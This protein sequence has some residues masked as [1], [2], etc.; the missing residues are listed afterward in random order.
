MDSKHAA[1]KYVENLYQIIDLGSTNGTFVNDVEILQ[2]EW[3]D[4]NSTKNLRFGNLKVTF[5]KNQRLNDD[6]GLCNTHNSSSTKDISTENT[7][8]HKVTIT[9]SLYF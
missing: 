6:S 3:I 7:S 4:I 1:I 2:F 5:N 8:F 9:I